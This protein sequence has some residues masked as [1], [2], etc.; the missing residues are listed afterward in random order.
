MQSALAKVL[1]LL[2]ITLVLAIPLAQIGHLIAERGQSQSQA[3]AE[4]AA[5]HAGPQLLTGPLLV[6][7]YVERWNELELDEWARTKR[8]VQRSREAVHLVFPERVDLA[9]QLRPEER[10]RG[11]FTVL[12]YSLEGK[13]NGRFAAFDAATLPRTQKESTIEV[14]APSLAIGLSDVRGLQG[15]PALRL[16]GEAVRLQPRV[17]RLPEN[18]PLAKGVHAALPAAAL[19]AWR[20]G[21]PLP[22]E[23]QL[24]LVGQGRFAVAPVADETTAHLTSPWPHPSF[25]GRFLATRR[26]VG[27]QGFEATW[28]VSSLVSPARGQ[29]QAWALP[30]GAEAQAREAIHTFDVSFAQPV[31]VYSMS[32]R[33]VKYGLLF[34]GLTLMAAFMF[35]LFRKLRLHP[36]QYGLVGLSIALFFL[37]LLALSEKLAFATAYACAASAS[38]LLLSVYFRAVLQGWGRGLT[39]GG[40]VAV[41]YAALYGL[42]AS[43]DN[44]LLLGSLLLFGLLAVLMLATRKV[45]WYAL[46]SRPAANAAAA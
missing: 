27:P 14:L 41:L 5:S 1:V 46:S 17:P 23:M 21:Q 9:G 22:F 35:E 38:V 45:D 25:G 19:Q 28:A 42:L 11:I 8:Q 31:N 39:L 18:S 34:V 32:N 6:V 37:L 16:A 15:T 40:F 2:F 13:L 30:G 43:E 26:S 20:A 7:P 10:Y 44:A 12:F 24:T 36:V 4:L 33:A 3:E 29:V